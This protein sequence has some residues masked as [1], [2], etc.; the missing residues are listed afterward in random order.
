MKR[1]RRLLALVSL[2][3]ACASV[4]RRDDPVGLYG[5]PDGG[6]LELHRSPHGILRGHLRSGSRVA[7]LAP[8]EVRGAA[9]H[10]LATYDD[11]SRA[12]L[13]ASLGSE[14]VRKAAEAPAGEAVRREIVESY[15]RLGR[16]VDTKDYAAFQALRLPEF[17]TIPPDGPPKVA[18]QMADRARGLLERIQPPITNT[19]DILE[20]TVRGED[21]LATVRQKFRRK[22]VVGD[23]LEEIYTEVT[24][25]ET[26]TRTPDG[27]KL[28]F[29]DEVRD[30][31]TWREG[32]RVK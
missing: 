1:M 23:H 25:R 9:L 17:A 22:Q 24:Q 16:A 11:G 19:N 15:A 28:A 20:L 12:E 14:Y 29:V 3:I 13:S 7:A 4:P 27:W 26:W 32:Q 31:A 21:A 10:A 6:V 2:S 30:A 18:A 5:S 8:V